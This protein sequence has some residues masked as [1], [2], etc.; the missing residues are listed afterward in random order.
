MG[1]DTPIT[2]TLS[3]PGAEF[4]ARFEGFQSE[5]YK[6]IA[7]HLTIGFGHRITPTEDLHHLTEGEALDLLMSDAVRE[8]RPVARALKVPVE[9]HEA[10]ALISLAFNCGGNAIARSTLMMMLN[11]GDRTG[12]AEQFGRWN[13]AGGRE[14][15]GLTR[16]RNA[17]ALLFLTGDY[18]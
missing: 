3:R 15:K 8:A 18:E 14:S 5:Q 2:L 17:E 6:D 4:I 9:Q 12:A 11:T 1:N 7:G 10:D 16:R 13:K